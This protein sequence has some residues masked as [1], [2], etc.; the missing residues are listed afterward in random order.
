MSH[1][2]RGG[3]SR[4]Q[5]GSCGKKRHPSKG[6]AKNHAR[7]LQSDTGY[8]GEP[9]FCRACGGWHVGG[10]MGYVKHNQSAK[11]RIRRQRRG[12]P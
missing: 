1:K 4:A 2:R 12:E 3:E 7:R 9:Y 10:K 8:V 6:R 5:W 11:E